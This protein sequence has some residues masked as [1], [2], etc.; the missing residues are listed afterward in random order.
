MKKSTIQ[1]IKKKYLFKNSWN[2]TAQK[3]LNELDFSK[4]IL[5]NFKISEFKVCSQLSALL[6][7][8]CMPPKEIIDIIVNGKHGGKRTSIGNFFKNYLMVDRYFMNEFE[9]TKNILKAS[10]IDPSPSN[11]MKFYAHRFH[12]CKICGKLTLRTFCSTKCMGKDQTR[13]EQFIVNM[14][15]VEAVKKRQKTCLEKYGDTSVFG[16]NSEIVKNIR[17]KNI[18]KYGFENVMS[19]S[20]PFRKNAEKTSLDKY[21]VKHFNNR[22]KCIET[23][24]KNLGVNY[25]LQMNLKNFEFL[26]AEHVSK[27]F[28]DASKNRFMLDEFKSFFGLSQAAA[29]RYKKKFGL[30][31]PSLHSRQSKPQLELFDSIKTSNKIFNDREILKPLELDIV[32]PNINLAIEYDG[33]FWHSSKDKSQ[34]DH[35]NKTELCEKLGYQLFHIFD[36]D[37]IEIWKSM[38]DAKLG[39]TKTIYARKCQIQEISLDDAQMFCD[40]NHLQGGVDAK[41]NIGL[42]HRGNLVAV[43]Q[44]GEHLDEGKKYDWELKRFCQLK[45]FRIIGGAGKMLA[46]FRKNYAGSIVSYGNR[47]WTN[48]F[49]YKVLGF[50]FV[51]NTPPDFKY[52]KNGSLISKNELK[53]QNFEKEGYRKLYDCG[54]QVWELI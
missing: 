39:F 6:S 25:A 26:N 17:H 4:I 52:F 32:L 35:L 11:V 54:N 43:M 36:T 1:K 24:L 9:A 5:K 30:A 12:A 34:F 53:I 15:S 51:K 3:F 44:F 21:G 29:Y 18:E 22:K 46:W 50:K 14:T 49:L 13:K 19:A 33:S 37:D 7:R 48:G 16:K 40:T 28:V 47:R 27:N 8:K 31:M 2:I 38:I 23:N 10:S 45:G 20:S 41:V 42:N